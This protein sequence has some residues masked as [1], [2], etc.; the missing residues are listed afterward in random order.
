MSTDAAAT[1]NK[2][3]NYNTVKWML[4]SKYNIQLLT[5]TAY[6]PNS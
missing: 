4:S 2:S 5:A 1:T 3:D 6:L